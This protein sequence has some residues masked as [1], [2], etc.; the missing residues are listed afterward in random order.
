MV[1]S[2]A[3]IHPVCKALTLVVAAG[4]FRLLIFPGNVAEPGAMA[5]L[6][7]LAAYLDS[8]SSIIT[9]YTPKS[10]PRHSVIDVLTIHSSD[11]HA[12]ELYDFPQPSI[13]PA[14]DPHRAYKKIYCDGPSYHRGDGRAYEAYGISKEVGA[15]VVVRPDMHTALVA[16]LEDV[17]MLERY[18]GGFMLEAEGGGSPG[19][20]C[21]VVRHPVWESEEEGA[22][23]NGEA[24][25]APAALPV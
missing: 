2:T 7:K 14:F 21:G 22:G 19:S 24:V 11:R 5:R 1:S 8:A 13:F 3:R 18:F 23:A 4:S 9:K 16:G 25:E 10:R 15:V 17:E 20:E 6:A 12:L